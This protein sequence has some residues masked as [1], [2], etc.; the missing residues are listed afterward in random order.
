MNLQN[1]LRDLARSL[2]AG[3]E[4]RREVRLLA[5]GLLHG[6]DA[7]LLYRSYPREVTPEQETLLRRAVKRRATGEPLQHILEEAWFYGRRFRSDARALVPRP[8]TETLVEVL[9]AE[10]YPEPP[11]FLDVGTGSGIIGITLALEVPGCSVT[12][13]EVRPEAAALARENGALLGAANYR[14]VE[15][16]LVTGIQGPFH[17]VAANLPYIP[18]GD[19]PGL[20]R[21]VC[22]DPVTALDGGPTG[23]ERIAALLPAL[24]P[25]MPPGA[26]LALE[27]G[28]DQTERVR[29]LLRGWT[30]TRIHRD[31]GGRPRV[32]TARRAD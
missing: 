32:V 6:G 17:A 4:A 15:T 16:D 12:G 30:D 5:A 20:P 27:T 23:L 22:F 8:E 14:V 1:M 26:L 21:E 31:P 24:P 13:T 10:T 19:L 29:D 18:A 2:P 7:A 25:L 28:F 3:G 11:R 9:L